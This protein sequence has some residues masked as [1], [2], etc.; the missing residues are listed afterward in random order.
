[1]ASTVNI[2][3]ALKRRLRSQGITYKQA[4]EA[5]ELSE[6]S[7]KR[8]FAE[9]SFSL[10]RIEKLCELANTDFAE[11]VQFADAAQQQ[12]DQL[13]LEQEQQLVADA[14]LLL[15]A[16]CIINYMSFADIIEKYDYNEPAL[17]KS[18]TMLDKMNII[19]L[20]PNNRYRLKL[21]RRFSLQP[22]G[23]IQSFFVNNMLK[24]FLSRKSA[25]EKAPFQLAWGMLSKNSAQE[26]QKKIQR[27]FDEYLQIAEHDKRIPVSEKLTS[28]LFIMFHE[29]MEPTL[30]TQQQKNT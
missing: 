19:E 29:D 20:L 26:L 3:S 12:L 18:F 1:M 16:V 2:L 25:Q 13:S 30:F 8:L 4:A 9:R 14:N 10:L 27:L 7:I 17:I 24:E 5:L 21:N 15:V 11:L 22:N 23:P 28:S 6:V